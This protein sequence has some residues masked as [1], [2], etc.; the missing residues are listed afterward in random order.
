MKAGGDSGEPGEARTGVW[1]YPQSGL[2]KDLQE[3][4]EK[5]TFKF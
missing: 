4:S 1:A 2:V 3:V 5:S